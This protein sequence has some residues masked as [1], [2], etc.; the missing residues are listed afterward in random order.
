MPVWKGIMQQMENLVFSLNATV[1]VFLMMILGLF[2][3]KIGFI[4]DTLADEMNKFVFLIPLPVLVFSDL[5]TVDF[6]EVWNMKFVLFCFGATVISIAISTAVSFLWK[7]KSIPVSYTHLVYGMTAF[8]MIFICN[9]CIYAVMK[10]KYEIH[11][12]L[13][14]SVR[15][16]I[17]TCLLYTSIFGTESIRHH[18]GLYPDGFKLAS[19]G[20]DVWGVLQR[21][22]G[23]KLS[24]HDVQQ[25]C[26]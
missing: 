18:A 4:S 5:A 2:F 6:E 25:Y 11:L 9:L 20:F 7:D 24:V 14:E 8:G 26:L 15:G 10:Q 13:M 22:D 21:S 19:G 3:K 23:K 12:E 1:P 17:Y 16:L